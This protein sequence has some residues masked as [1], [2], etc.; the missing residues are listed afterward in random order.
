[1]GKLY[2]NC[3]VAVL[4]HRSP[5]RDELGN[6]GSRSES[7]SMQL[8]SRSQWQTTSRRGG[9]RGGP[10]LHES[11]K[12]NNAGAFPINISVVQD[13][14]VEDDFKGQPQVMAI[15]Q[16]VSGRQHR[17]PNT[18]D[19]WETEDG[20]TEVHTTL[21][22]DGQRLIVHLS[23]R[24]QAWRTDTILMA[25]ARPPVMVQQLT[26]SAD[27][28]LRSFNSYG[29]RSCCAVL[30]T[31]ATCIPTCNLFVLSYYSASTC[32]AEPRAPLRVF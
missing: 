3:L 12:G 17:S 27:A 24:Y 32:R 4:N 23:C 31:T 16:P 9:G 2:T 18:P 15:T 5:E 10:R 30:H 26:R 19:S 6:T 14:E 11:A 22:V 13:V 21:D 1:M 7:H 20:P 8:N 25:S 28:L 29:H